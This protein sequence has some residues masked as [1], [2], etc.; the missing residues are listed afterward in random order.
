M[1]ILGRMVNASNSTLVVR[2]DDRKFIYKPI[3]GER[4]LWDF[5]EGTLALR[6]RAAYVL[7]E[8]GQWHV[9]PHTELREGPLGLGSFQAWVEADIKDVAV[10][11][12]QE[13][14][15]G[16]IEIIRGQ[17]EHGQEVALIHQDKAEL[18]AIALFDA[19]ANNADR[20]GG[21]LLTDDLGN[22]FAIDHGVTFNEEPKLRTVLWGYINHE[23]TDTEVAQL[24]EVR[25]LI[26]TS[27]LVELLNAQEITALHNRINELLA[28]GKFP[29]PSPN[30][31]SIPW[32]AF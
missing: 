20:K 11:A 18:R 25:K 5:P 4:P 30:W 16:W 27:E 2:D 1:E 29:E 7:S 23:F 31:P 21:H 9:V 6:E 10:V 12:P 26:D 32:P 8:L 28:S 17:D 13:V 3:T 22:V 19:V 15:A 14:D 24:E